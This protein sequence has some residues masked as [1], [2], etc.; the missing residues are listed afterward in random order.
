MQ[1]RSEWSKIF[2]ALKGNIRTTK[3]EFYTSEIIL[4]KWRRNF[5]S[6]PSYKVITQDLKQ[7]KSWTNWKKSVTFWNVSEIEVLRQ[8]ATPKSGEGGKYRE[9][10]WRIIIITIIL[11]VIQPLK[12]TRVGTLIWQFWWVTESWVWIS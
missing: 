5:W 4:Q 8:T 10:Q 2:K 9:F 6:A 1:A 3:V 7:E 11:M 12:Q